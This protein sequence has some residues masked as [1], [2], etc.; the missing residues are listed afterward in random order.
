MQIQTKAKVKLSKADIIE[1]IDT[2]ME[3]KG[4]ERNSA[5]EFRV[6][7][8]DNLRSADFEAIVK[9]AKKGK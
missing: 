8:K 5:I 6:D 9:D 4:I 1:A 7:A 3:A 2:V